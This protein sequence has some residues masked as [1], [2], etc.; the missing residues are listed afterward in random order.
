MNP[1]IV[2]GKIIRK[3]FVENQKQWVGKLIGQVEQE[4]VWYANWVNVNSLVR[5]KRFQRF[6]HLR[7]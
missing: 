1:S 3:R 2:T 7:S 4:A 6:I 5:I